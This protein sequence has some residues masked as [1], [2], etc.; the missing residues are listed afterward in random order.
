MLD[1]LFGKKERAVRAEDS[2]WISNGARLRGIRREVDRLVAEKKSTVV[3]ALAREDFDT[4]A[5]ELAQHNPSH[6]RDLFGLA[7]LQNKVNRAGSVT[8]ALADVLSASAHQKA[9]GDTPVDFIVCGRGDS[10]AADE[11]LLRFADIFGPTTK[12]S[13]HVSLDDRILSEHVGKIKPLL[14][15]L[16]LSEDDAISSP[17]VTRAIGN[18]RRK[19]SP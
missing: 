7:K 13:F 3:V 15:R 16:G 6:C 11:A 1:W 18:A 14:A 5:R 8:I 9:E 10:R 17:V 2:V 19:K 12:I 4:L